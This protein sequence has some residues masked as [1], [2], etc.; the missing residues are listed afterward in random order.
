MT[1]QPFWRRKTLA[2]MT[3]EEWESLCDGCGQ[4]CLHKLEDAGSGEITPTDVACS[5]LDLGSCRCSDYKNR[6]TN[7][8]D[9]VSLTPKLV[10][11]LRW[12]PATCAYRLVE[13]GRDLFWWHP[14]ISGNQKSVHEA[15]ISVRGKAVS[16][17]DVEDIEQRTI[18]QLNAVRR[19]L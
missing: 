17:D 10:S 16:E 12:L 19:N 9:C 15:G 14:L 3:D 2:Q 18:D 7:V 1:D 6:Q 4:C 13:E 8:P 11:T 5:Y